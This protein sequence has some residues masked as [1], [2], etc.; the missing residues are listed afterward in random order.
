MKKFVS[1]CFALVFALGVDAQDFTTLL[2]PNSGANFVPFSFTTT[3]K[4]RT[5]YRPGDF[6]ITP[7]SGQ[8]T[9]IYLASASGSG[10]GTWSDFRISIGQTTDTVLNSTSFTPG[11]TLCLQAPSFTIPSVGTANP[12]IPFPLTTSFVYDASQSLIVEI[13]YDERTSGSGFTVRSNTLTGRDIVLSGSTQGA[14]S[15]T[16]GAAQ[17]TLGIDVQSL[18]GTDLAMTAFTS[19]QPPF[20][21]GAPAVVGVSF[22]NVATNTINLATLNYQVGNGPVVTET[23]SGSVASLQSGNFNFITPATIP[24]TGDSILRVWVSDVNGSGDANQANDTIEQLLCLPLAAGSYQI[25][26]PTPD[27]VDLGAFRERL[28]CSGIG[29]AVVAQLAPGIYQGPFRFNNISGTAA[30]NTI[31][32]VS[33][34][35]QAEDVKFY[36]PAGNEEALS[37]VGTQNVALSGL[38]FVRTSA[39]TA[40]APLLVVNNASNISF[41]GLVFLDSSLTSSINNIGLLIDGGA[42]NIV[43]NSTFSGFGEPVKLNGSGGG[44]GSSNS[45]IANT[46]NKYTANAISAT[47]QEQLLVEGNLIRNYVGATNAGAGILLNG[48]TNANVSANRIGGFLG[49]SGI[50][51]NNMNIGTLSELNIIANNEISGRTQTAN[52]ATGIT[53]GIW[54][55]G[56]IANGRDGVA[57]L[58]NTV[59]FVPLGSNTAATQGLLVVDGGTGTTQPFD[60]LVILNNIFA[61]GIATS[62][63]PANFGLVVFSNA[64]TADSAVIGYNNYYRPLENLLAP[65]FRVLNPS[66]ATAYNIYNEWR[67]DYPQDSASVSVRPFFVADS[68]LIPVSIA[69]DNLGLPLASVTTDLTGQPRDPV[70]PDMGAYEFTGQVISQFIFTPLPNTTDTSDRQVVVSINDS[71]GIVTGANGPRIYYRKLGQ[72]AFVVDTLPALVGGNTYEFVISSMALGGVTPGDEIE[73]YFAVLNNTGTVTTLPIGGGGTGPIGNI[74]PQALFSYEI[75]PSAQGTYRVG[76]G[77]DFATITEAVQFANTSQFTGNATFVLIDNLYS[78]NETFPIVFTGNA[79]RNDSVRAIFRPDSGVVATISGSL[80]ATTPSLFLFEDANHISLMGN[81]EG[82]SSRNL[83]ITTTSTNTNTALIRLIGNQ[84]AGSDHL[85]FSHLHLLAAAPEVNLQYGIFVGG[86]AISATSEGEHKHVHILHNQI[87]RI[88]QAIYIRG[89]GSRPAYGSMIIGNQLGSDLLSHKLAARG[90]QVHNTDSTLISQNRMR[91]II[92]GLAVQKSGVESSGSQRLLVI[93]RNDI[94]EVAHTTFS[95]IGQG[96]YG[97]FLNGGNNVEITNNV[98]AGMRGGNVGNASYTVACGIRIQAGTGHRLYYNTIHLFGEYDQPATGG[99]SAA[100]LAITNTAVN[101]LDVRNNIFSNQLSSVSTSTGIYFAAIWLAQNYN[102]ATSTFDHN[103]YAVRNNSQNLVARFGNFAGQLYLQEL[104][105]FLAVVQSSN[106]TNDLNSIPV[107]GKVPA[108]FISDTVLVIDTTIATPYE[109]AGVVI[110]GLGVPNIDF[111][112]LARP[113]FGGNAPD[114]GA[115]EFAGLEAGDE[116]APA[117]TF[118]LLNPN[119][120]ACSP[121]ARQFSLILED[122]TGVETANLLYRVNNGTLQTVAMTLD[123]GTVLNGRWIANIPAAG[124][125]DAVHM[126]FVGADSVGNTTDSLRLGTF[127]DAYLSIPTQNDTTM[128]GLAQLGRT[129]LGNAGGLKLTEVFYNRLLTG[130][131]P[132]YPTGFPT[133]SSQVAIEITNTSPQVQQLGGIHLKVEGFYSQDF[134]LPA[135]SL[136]SGEVAV[137]V[138]GSTTNQTANRIFGWGTAG[139]A[140]PFNSSNVVGIWLEAA[141]TAEVIDAVSINGHGFSQASGVNSFEFSGSVTAA[142]RASIQR[143][144]NAANNAAAWVA[145]DANFVSTIGHVNPTLQIDPGFYSWR[146]A[147]T[148][149]LLASGPVANFSP[150]VSGAYILSYTDSICSVSDTFNI[151]VLAPDLAITAF[152]N[153]TANMVVREA[154]EI[155]VRVKNVGTSTVQE[156][157]NFRYSVNN[158][159]PTNPITV[160]LNLDPGDST[161]VS[162]TPNWIPGPAG[163]YNIC[164]FLGPLAAD[165]NRANDSLCVTISSAVSVD[166]GA[167]DGLVLYPNP[168]NEQLRIDGLPERAVVVISNALGQEVFRTQLSS[169]ESHLQ[170]QIGQWPKGMYQAH[171][172]HNSAL[173]VRKFVISR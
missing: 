91:N 53:R 150:V 158:T 83:T 109:S 130:A 119:F 138:A 168:A 26:G 132:S 23:F 41:L 113:A 172:Q 152:I 21:P 142:N 100:A 71:V 51:A 110:A 50:E 54:L 96:S 78:T 52:G 99:S 167:L 55:T 86:G 44:L 49:R 146:L 2:N 127:R 166:E 3:R 18:A 103:A 24:T 95:G 34:S 169:G 8:I 164:A 149:A 32:F 69:F 60:S 126:Y 137:I 1:L 112:G 90:V 165:P 147:S 45:V 70:T 62:Q 46:F 63:S 156:S 98:I 76:V 61:E 140:S 92:S 161:E 114:L 40:P 27:F 48:L 123:T 79:S 15:G 89:I 154:V 125:G 82:D 72:S 160:A 19:P 151:T 65:Q 97:I 133:G 163:N 84:N 108:P 38:T 118:P 145:S 139:G 144:T 135:I 129:A 155:R 136:D 122:E 30:G 57:L 36:P 74:P 9:T 104:P 105:D 124:A 5:I 11:L 134:A 66:P 153:P 13:S 47:F 64:A 31:T 148:A 12:Y 88:W 171:I 16:L 159:L 20:T 81:W 68:L 85:E 101:N 87:E 121:T 115:I 73:Y 77:G 116:L 170:L 59:S 42:S 111:F 128:N 56:N 94:R 33:L 102:F 22:Q 107:Q 10:G 141:G 173:R 143:L 17:R 29:G 14:T 39:V 67:L 93:S 106:P 25:G 157:V 6:L 28:E 4:I 58:H 162:I 120:N 80:S 131:Q 35:G 75:T 117:L 37:F 7:N 43:T